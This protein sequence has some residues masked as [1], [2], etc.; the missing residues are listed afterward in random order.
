VLSELARQALIGQ[1]R[2]RTVQNA[3]DSHGFRP[4]P[5]R[6]PIVSRALIEQL[7]EDELA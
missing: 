7:R 5:A 4:L 2:A 3:P 1:H 6:G